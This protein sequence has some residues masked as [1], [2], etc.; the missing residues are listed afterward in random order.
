MIGNPPYVSFKDIQNKP[1]SNLLFHKPNL[2]MFFFEKAI[3]DL[4][5]NGELIFIV[6]N[7]ILTNTSNR[8]INEEIYNNFSITYW[9]LITENIWEN[10]SVPTAIIKII[11]TKNHKDKLNYFFNNGKIIFGEKINWNGKT[12]VKVGGAS[13]FNSLLEN[14]D[15]EFVFS[16]T[17]RTNKTKFIKYEPLKWNRPVPKYPLNFSFQIFVNAKTR[18]NKPFYILKKLQK[19]E[20]IN[21][22]ASVICIYTFGSKEETLELVNKLNNYDWTNAGIKNDGRFHFSQSIIECI[23]N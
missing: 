4:N 21:Y 8:K 12:E 22:D 6:P 20:F 19:N 9:E 2:Y 17:E 23:L 10:A 14:G 1:Q 13:G 3:H 15:V 16:E 5:E 11:K 7:S 18:N